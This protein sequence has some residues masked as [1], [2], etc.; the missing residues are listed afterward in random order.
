MKKEIEELIK[1]FRKENEGYQQEIEN[2]CSS[3]R[4]TVI[5]HLYNNNLKHIEKLENI[6]KKY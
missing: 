6:L 2:G 3:Y 4:H 5:V 1:E